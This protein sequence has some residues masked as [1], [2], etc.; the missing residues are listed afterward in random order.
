MLPEFGKANTWRALTHVH[1]LV[2]KII[3]CKLRTDDVYVNFSG[4]RSVKIRGIDPLRVVV[5]SLTIICDR[6]GRTDVRGARISSILCCFAASFHPYHISSAFDLNFSNS[7][8]LD[9]LQSTGSIVYFRHGLLPSQMTLRV[10]VLDYIN[11]IHH[12]REY[13]S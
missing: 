4:L 13:I 8:P 10:E 12:T 1:T 5:W 6:S 9:I 11:S 3:A 7:P 2:T